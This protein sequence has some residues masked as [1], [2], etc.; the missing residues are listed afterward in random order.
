MVRNVETAVDGL[1]YTT[2]KYGVGIVKSN[3]PS[4]TNHKSIKKMTLA[5]ISFTTW[6]DH[7]TRD[8]AA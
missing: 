5:E 4:V 1:M 8:V 6:W 2:A 3:P 7:Y